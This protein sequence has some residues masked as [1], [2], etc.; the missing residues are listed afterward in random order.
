MIVDGGYISNDSDGT[1]TFPKICS[2]Y[3]DQPGASTSSIP[4][5]THDKD[6]ILDWG[7]DDMDI[8]L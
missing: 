5:V 1:I 6:E 8:T 7:H 3:L 4:I 2:S